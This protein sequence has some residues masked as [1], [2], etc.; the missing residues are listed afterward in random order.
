MPRILV[1]PITRPLSLADYD[2]SLKFDD[3]RPAVVQVWV[4]PTRTWYAQ[5]Q[6]IGRQAREGADPEL[7]AGRLYALF[8]QLWSQGPD[9]WTADE[10]RAIAELENAP[11]L[12]AWL[13]R[14]S[15]E[16]LAEF[17]DARLKA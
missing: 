2:T 17:R 4:N 1:P 15:D 13:I 8:A 11:G 9:A 12:L 3:G 10:V 14:R 16:I 7:V 6:E 5:R